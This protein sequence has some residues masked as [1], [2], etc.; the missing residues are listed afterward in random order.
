MFLLFIS[1]VFV[2]NISASMGWHLFFDGSMEY[3]LLGPPPLLL[4]SWVEWNILLFLMHGNCFNIISLDFLL[5]LSVFVDECYAC[6]EFTLC[7]D[8][9]NAS[10]YLLSLFTCLMQLGAGMS[11]TTKRR[12]SCHTGIE[13]SWKPKPTFYQ[14]NSRAFII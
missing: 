11:R 13:T 14:N 3:R 7:Q 5:D 9:S 12:R 4:S 10:M 1:A 8:G 6:I 2:A